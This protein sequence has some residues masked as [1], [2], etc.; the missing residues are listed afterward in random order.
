MEHHF[1]GDVT[2]CRGVEDVEAMGEDANGLQPTVERV[3]VRMD[4]NAVRQSAD[5]EHR[6]AQLVQVSDKLPDEILAVDGA[7]PRADDVDDVRLVEVGGTLIEQCQRR[8]GT[9]R[10][11]LGIIGGVEREDLDVM[12][13]VVGQLFLAATTHVIDG[14]QCL[15]DVAGHVGIELPEVLPLFDDGRCRPH[16]AVELHHLVEVVIAQPCED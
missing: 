1:V 9:L 7:L 4:V 5:D 3:A 12:F 14:V 16:L 2:V 6:R 11:P 15:V 13:T 10:Q 8:V